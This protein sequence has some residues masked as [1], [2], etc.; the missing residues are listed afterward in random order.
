[1]RRVLPDWVAKSLVGVITLV[2]GVRLWLALVQ[3]FNWDETALLSR[4]WILLEQGFT[5]ESRPGLVR[6]LLLPLFY[7]FDDHVKLLFAARA[8]ALVSCGVVF[9][10]VWRL[11]R[12][13][14]GREVALL[15]LF[16]LSL[17]ST[18]LVHSVEIR[19][20]ALSSAFCLLAFAW[21]ETVWRQGRPGLAPF[22][23]VG[24]GALASQKA[25]YDVIWYAVAKATRRGADI[26]RRWWMKVGAVVV[27]PAVIL[28][29]AVALVAPDD[30][31][32][33]VE[34]VTVGALEEARTPFYVLWVQWT[35]VLKSLQREPVF[36]ALPLLSLPFWFTRNRRRLGRLVSALLLQLTL[37]GILWFH[38][39]RFPYFFITLAPLWALPAG[40]QLWLVFLALKRLAR[41]SRLVTLLIL[42]PLILS[43]VLPLLPRVGFIL[44]PSNTSQLALVRTLQ[45][46]FAP[47]TRVF[48]ASHL[49]FKHHQV[50]EPLFARDIRNLRE[51][52]DWTTDLISR[53]RVSQPAYFL[54]S[55]RTDDFPGVL[56]D[57]LFTRFVRLGPNIWVAGAE[58]RSPGN[59]ECVRAG[60]YLVQ[61]VKRSPEVALP[62]PFPE[63]ARLDGVIIRE[64]QRVELQEGYHYVGWSGMGGVR[65]RLNLPDLADIEQ[66]HLRNRQIFRSY[67]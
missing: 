6:A 41:H 65:F 34:R 61:S 42:F 8:V 7:L 1:M 24:A 44:K 30:V 52:P 27:L 11:G 20:E 4:S 33:F 55:K 40:Y 10:S 56:R 48:D 62:P 18:Y 39:A 25:L 63:E 57:Y 13:W 54:E 12:L 14:Y 58:R 17:H 67:K 28:I 26:P 64:G 43:F 3:I 51:R 53:L 29:G 2:M 45:T 16:L 9:W 15:S 22:A 19:T 35:F 49:M 36:Y 47:D 46:H 21:A 50:E 37:V 32:P 23:L 59:F 38:A 60:V 31:A 66:P 5:V